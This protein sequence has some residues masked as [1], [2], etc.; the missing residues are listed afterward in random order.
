MATPAVSFCP[1]TTQHNAASALHHLAAAAEVVP[2]TASL[3]DV[4]FTMYCNGLLLAADRGDSGST[5]VAA[6]AAVLRLSSDYNLSQRLV[7]AK[8]GAVKRTAN[9]TY[10]VLIVNHASPL[11]AIRQRT[12]WVHEDVIGGPRIQRG[13]GA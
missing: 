10:V 9:R 2:R 4:H 7:K 11:D 6:A 13:S 5:R 3:F 8:I 12:E 1:S